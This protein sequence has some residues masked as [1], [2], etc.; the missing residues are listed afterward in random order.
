M[1]YKND[2]ILVSVVMAFWNGDS[3]EFVKIAVESI[4]KQTHKNLEL[5]ISVGGKVSEDKQILLKEFSEKDSRVKVLLSDI[6]TGPSFSRNRAIEAASGEYCAIADSDD[7]FFADKIEKQ[8]D[9]ITKQ[10][11][12]FLGCGYLEFRNNHENEKGKVRIMPKT[13]RDIVK[14]L[15]FANPIANSALFIKTSVLKEFMYDEKFRPGEGEDYDLV[16]RLLRAKKTAENL[17]TPLFFYRLGDNFEKKHAN[18][19]CG[20]KD[21]QHKFKASAVLP[22]YMFPAIFFVAAIAFVSRPLPPKIFNFLR[23]LRHRIF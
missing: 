11:L 18:L 3:N 1:R 5:I 22:F 6:N 4:L 20:I 8:L 13:N 19:N 10:N 2:E 12:D 17:A 7:I 9:F 16:I 15:P 23:D 14:S 21:L